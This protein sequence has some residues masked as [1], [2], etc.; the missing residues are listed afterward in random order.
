GAVELWRRS[1]AQF[2]DA[3]K[4]SWH[5]GLATALQKLNQFDDAD[6]VYARGREI[7]PDNRR[8]WTGAAANAAARKEWPAAEAL[9]NACIVR[10]GDEAVASWWVSLSKTMLQQGRFAEA[11]D[12]CRAAQ[13]RF[14]DE[15]TGW[16]CEGRLASSRHLWRQAAHAFEIAAAKS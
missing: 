7:W 3:A 13:Q 14:P 11:R 15:G 16:A 2:P 10:F 9:W 8:G 6:A 12:A 1:I 5:L 4:A